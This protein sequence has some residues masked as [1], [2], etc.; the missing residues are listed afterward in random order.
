MVDDEGVAVEDELVLPA[1]DR[2][3]RERRNVLAGALDDERLAL[4]ALA[5]VVGGR[6][7]VD[8]SVAPASAASEQGGPGCQMSSQ[9]VTPMR[10]SPSS[11]IPAPVPERK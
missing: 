1:D 3:E 2:A 5:R 7:E 9:I 6:G 8:D 4:E 11:M 10:C